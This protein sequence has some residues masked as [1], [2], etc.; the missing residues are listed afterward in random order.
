MNC[1]KK[2]F[3]IFAILFFVY[4]LIFSIHILKPL[5]E[6][7][8]Y[9]SQI[10]NISDSDIRFLIDKTYQ[11]GNNRI[12]EQEIFSTIFSTIQ[13]ATDFVLVDMFLFNTNYN[14]EQA[15]N[16]FS[17][18]TQLMQTLIDTKNAKPKMSVVFITDSFNTLYNSYH[19]DEITQLTRNNISVVKTDMMQLRDSNP[20]YSAS[21]RM[22]LTYI[23]FTQHIILPHLFGDSTKSTTLSGL[24]TLLNFKANHRKIVL[25]K[26]NQTY[27]SIITSANPHEASSLHSNIAFLLNH[28]IA[29]DILQTEQA[30]LSLNTNIT[31]PKSD[32]QQ[33]TG[34]IQAQYVTEKKIIDSIIS[35]I[36]QTQKGDSITV[37]TFYI[38][39]RLLVEELLLADKRGV[40]V[41]LVLDP[42][43]DA[44]GNEKS[45]IPNRQVAFELYKLSK[46]SIQI[47]WYNTQGE[48]FHSKMIVIQTQNGV[49]I[50]GGSANYTR[51]NVDNYNLEANIR[52][53][54]P[55]DTRLA[56][57]VLGYLS[58]IMTNDGGTFTLPYESYKD[59]SILRYIIYRFQERT[60]LSTF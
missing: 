16:M 38:S 44:F 13:H 10:Y 54:T 30:V 48:Q 17:I 6:N 32:I 40:K 24:F 26:T 43:K 50:H 47:L 7:I 45:G 5:P 52:L 58:T 46:E 9:K 49:I 41:Q 34:P 39:H 12:I 57:D 37:A 27:Q 60:G 4:I 23:P 8:S 18:T 31:L 14:K 19:I 42:N 33:T 2:L 29:Q 56:N 25:A 15:P 53:F 3:G 1:K 20:I 59:H 36:R 28:T 51:R 21:Y 11:R 22:L 55:Y 35:D